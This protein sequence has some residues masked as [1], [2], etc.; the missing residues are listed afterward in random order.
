MIFGIRLGDDW[1]DLADFENVRL[2]EFGDYDTAIDLNKSATE[3]RCL[4]E[5]VEGV[6]KKCPVAFA[7]GVEGTGEGVVWTPRKLDV[8]PAGEPEPSSYFFKVKGDEHRNVSSKKLSELKGYIVD[9]DKQLRVRE[10]VAAVTCEPRLRQGPEYL[11]E[12]GMSIDIKNV[13]KFLQWLNADILKEESD[14]MQEYAVKPVD[15]KK[16]LPSHALPWFKRYPKASARS[17]SGAGT[18]TGTNGPSFRMP[19]ICCCRTL[20]CPWAGRS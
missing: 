1:Q 19:S 9:G 6:E 2:P 11:V 12:M 8:G 15:I 16:A 3:Y 20:S 14:L 5:V 17:C 4:Q 7:L 10:F 13:G 18:T